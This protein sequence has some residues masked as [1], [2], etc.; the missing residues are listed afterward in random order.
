VVERRLVLAE[1]RSALLE[2]HLAP[3]ERHWASLER[4]SAPDGWRRAVRVAAAAASPGPWGVGLLPG[5]VRLSVAVVRLARR[6]AQPGVSAERVRQRPAQVALA[7]QALPPEARLEGSAEQARQRVAQAASAEPGQQPEARVASAQQA[8][9]PPEGR[10]AAAGRLPAADAVGA[11][12]DVEA[13]L[14]PE[15]PRALAA[16]VP[17]AAVA[18]AV[19]PA[20]AAPD[21]PALPL[22]VLSALVFRPDRLRW[23]APPRAVRFARATVGLRTASP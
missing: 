19:P 4:H 11:A 15:V 12:P 18:E 1:Q 6:R 14:R 9:L 3:R 10:D 8:A 2:P 5:R 13:A 21:A 7:E 20:W 23:P 22:A 17:G 16:E